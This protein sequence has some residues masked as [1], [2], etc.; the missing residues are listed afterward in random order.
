MYDVRDTNRYAEMYQRQERVEKVERL[1]L[2]L[3]AQKD[4]MVR[5]Q[6]AAAAAA[7]AAYCRTHKAAE[8][9]K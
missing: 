8:S 5:D 6:A 2:H 7:A 3:Q 9:R 4:L 1:R